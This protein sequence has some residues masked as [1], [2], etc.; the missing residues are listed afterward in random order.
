MTS[1]RKFIVA[2]AALTLAT[3]ALP[4]MAQQKIFSLAVTYLGSTT[5]T[6]PAPERPRRR[7]GGR[8][9]RTR[10]R[11]AIRRSTR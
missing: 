10:R 3:L 6:G 9:S 8:R 4:A 11:T 7:P 2:F 5:I 1:V